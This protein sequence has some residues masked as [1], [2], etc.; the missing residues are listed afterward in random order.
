MTDA[1]AQGIYLLWDQVPFGVDGWPTCP[2]WERAGVPTRWDREAIAGLA[3]DAQRNLR[4]EIDR[5]FDALE[6]WLE[7]QTRPRVIGYTLNP[8]REI[9]D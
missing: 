5:R 4:L 8:Y 6:D 7:E 9:R 3:E 1:L 2:A